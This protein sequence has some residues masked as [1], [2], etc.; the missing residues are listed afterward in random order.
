MIINCSD[1]AVDRDR[2]YMDTG[3]LHVYMYMYRCIYLLVCHGKNNYPFQNIIFDRPDEEQKINTTLH[4]TALRYTALHYTTVL[5]YTTLHYTTLHYTTLHCTTLH[6]TTLHYSTLY[7]NI[8]EWDTTN[9][10]KIT[11][12][13]FPKVAER[14]AQKYTSHKTS[15][16]WSRAT[17]T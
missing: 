9:K 2:Y 7:Y 12:D 3:I 16:L 5:Y 13:Y 14:L 4:Y 6:C 1:S 10:G 15:Q 11:K 17:G 8:L